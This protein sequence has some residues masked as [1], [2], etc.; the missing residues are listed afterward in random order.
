MLVESEWCSGPTDFSPILR[1]AASLQQQL[2]ALGSSG[3]DTVVHVI[4]LILGDAIARHASDVHFEPTSAGVEI[5]LRID[6]VLVRAAA[7]PLTLAPNVVAR[8]K[9]LADLLTYRVDVPQE[10]R[11]RAGV[12]SLPADMR[13]STFPTIHGE[14]VVVRVFGSSAG[15]LDFDQLGFPATVRDGLAGLLKERGGAVLLTGPSGSG[16]TTTIYACLRRVIGEGTGR[17][18]V[19]IEDP[20]ERH[21]PGVTQ[22]QARPGTEFDFARGLR[23]LL[24][25]DPD[26]IMVGEIRDRETAAVAIEA[27]LTG[28]LVFST[29][30]AGSACGVVSRLLE[31][32]IE[33]HLLT[34]G[35]KGILSQRLLRRVCVDCHGAGCVGCAATGFRGRLLVAELLI[36]DA[37]F[38]KQILARADT[39]TLEAA[40][41]SGWRTLR[42]EADAAVVDGRTTPAEVERVLGPRR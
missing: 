20:V 32:G 8:L 33:P 4:D 30:H 39:E 38:R 14:K 7:L 25:H 6:G 9:V 23:S 19:T 29:L 35:L 34:S 16:K 41:L 31:M 10:G 2:D 27:A 1:M 21:V 24:R 26:V 42:D 40:L 22:S 12:T 13:V 11:V 28:H 3:P 18:V 15:L 36:P 17:H 37:T 5:R